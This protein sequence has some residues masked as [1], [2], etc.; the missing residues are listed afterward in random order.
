MIFG[1]TGNTT[2][3]MIQGILPEVIAWMEER[4]ISYL[5]DRELLKLVQLP[6]SAKTVTMSELV[7]TC[8][9]MLAFGGDGTILAT[10]RSIGA[11][12]VPILGI[13][14][15]RLG[16][17]AEVTIEDLYER[18]EEIMRQ[19]YFILDRMVLEANISQGDRTQTFFALND[20]VIDR[21][22]FSRVIKIEVFIGEEFLNNYLGDGIIIATPTGSTA[23]SLSAY[24][25]ILAPTVNCVI[26]NP[27]C[28]HSLGVRPVVIP[29]DSIIRI[30]P[31][32]EGEMINVSIDG[33][34]S[35][36]YARPAQIEIVIRKAD[37]TIRWI[38]H[39]HRTFYD[40]LRAKL[41]WGADRRIEPNH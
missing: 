5:V 35:Q 28:P 25:P 34:W 18:L 24:G 20:V 3:S 37:H 30:I 14:I 22:G 13:N 8:D 17:L 12:G 23:Y 27:I 31:H 11:S 38:R 16:F 10:A 41:N 26:I 33:Q 21:G 4:K 29:D 39:Q 2:K 40:L 32:I 15:G 7:Q 1:I 9:I 6:S 19:E 36:K